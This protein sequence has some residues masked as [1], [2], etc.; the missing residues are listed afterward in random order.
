MNANDKNNMNP[1]D[2]NKYLGLRDERN[3]LSNSLRDTRRAIENYRGVDMNVIS[4]RERDTYDALRRYEGRLESQL[5]GVRDV[6]GYMED[7]DRESW[8]SDHD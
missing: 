2:Q 4:V 1:N 8:E 5:E 7:R 3:S 6:M